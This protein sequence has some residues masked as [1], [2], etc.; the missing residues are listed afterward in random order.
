MNMQERN[1][2]IDL[3]KGMGIILMVLGHSGFPFTRFIYLFHMAIFFMASGYCY[4][5]EDSES[6]KNSFKFVKRR[7]FSLWIPYIIWTTIFTLLHNIFISLNIYT[8]NPLILNYTSIGGTLSEVW[9]YKEM[10]KN[11]CLSFFL[12]G[13]TK[14]GGALWFICI[15]LKISFLYIFFDILIKQFF[16]NSILVQ[17]ILAII[18]LFI[19]YIFHLKNI[20]FLSLDKVF[21]YYCLFC[22]GYVIKR[23][24]LSDYFNAWYSRL[25][26]LGSAF[27]VLLICNKL[28]R[29]ELAE[30]DYVN[31]AFLII[32]SL[33]GWQLLYEIS[34]FIY[35]IPKISNIVIVIGKNTLAVVILHFLCFKIINLIGIF[36]T[37]SPIFLLACFPTYMKNGVW[38]LAYCFTGVS[39]PVL[40]SIGYKNIK[41][42]I[43]V[44]SLPNQ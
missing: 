43:I 39:I 17:G 7:V 19:G 27:I 35:Q 14:I 11:I 16:K 28:G 15:L 5:D 33:A 10:L 4:K 38:W 26:V 42:K 3:I 23:F 25:I 20:R 31:P 2:L 34:Y 9:S 8:T 18:F 13:G 6:I 12:S 41:Q 1:P 44:K 37:K 32:S 21:S 40:L 24:N 36:I 22:L 29:I 30:T